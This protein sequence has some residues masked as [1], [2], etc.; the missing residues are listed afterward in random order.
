MRRDNFTNLCDYALNTNLQPNQCSWIWFSQSWFA[1][2]LGLKSLKLQ[3]LDPRS[4]TKIA[5]GWYQYQYCGNII[6][7]AQT[8]IP[9]STKAT[10]SLHVICSLRCNRPV[11]VVRLRF[12]LFTEQILITA[13]S[14][15]QPTSNKRLDVTHTTLASESPGLCTTQT[16]YGNT[17]WCGVINV[18]VSTSLW[19]AWLLS[20]HWAVLRVS[21]SRMLGE[22]PHQQTTAPPTTDQHVTTLTATVIGN[23]MFTVG[24]Y[25]IFYSYSILSE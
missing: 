2:L 12:R 8:S 9:H 22:S 13:Q 19:C 3:V 20:G 21:W 18:T 4:D 7:I 25:R 16:V 15:L 1:T 14:A 24:L 11:N 6:L 17:L 5:T 10:V 23:T